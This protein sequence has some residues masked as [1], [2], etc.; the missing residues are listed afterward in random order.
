MQIMLINCQIQVQDLPNGGNQLVFVDEQRNVFI[1]PLEE[2][3]AKTIGAAL[4]S[5]IIVASQP[6]P[7]NGGKVN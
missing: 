1:A 6:L 5:G 3:A 4:T 2:Q 7:K